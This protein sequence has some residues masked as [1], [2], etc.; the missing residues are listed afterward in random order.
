[1]TTIMK[2]DADVSYIPEGMV[3]VSKE[4]LEQYQQFEKWIVDY[5]TKNGVPCQP[6]QRDHPGFSSWWNTHREN[7]RYQEQR[8]EMDSKI[9]KVLPLFQLIN[10]D[11]SRELIQEVLLSVLPESRFKLLRPI[12]PQ[13]VEEDDEDD[14]DEEAMILRKKGKPMGH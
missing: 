5:I 14:E 1:M 10:P 7:K 2:E 3:L 11:V 4:Q 6:W 12:E 13:V 8:K 9:D